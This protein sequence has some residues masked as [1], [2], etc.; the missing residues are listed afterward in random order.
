MHPKGYERRFLRTHDHFTPIS[1]QPMTEKAR[2][3]IFGE[4]LFDQFP[5]G[6]V[7]LGGAPFN[8][9]WHLQ[10]LGHAPLFIS[11]VGNDE[12]GSKIRHSMQQWGMDCSALQTD[13]HHPTGRVSVELKDGQP[14]FEILADQ[15]YDF[16]IS[17]QLPQIHEPHIIYHGSLALREHSSRATLDQLFETEN[18]QIFMDVNLRPPWWD[19][20]QVTS[21]LKAARWAKLNDVELNSLS[22]GSGD[23]ESQADALL[24]ACDLELLI[25]THGDQGAMAQKRDGEIARIRPQGNAEVMDTVGAGDAFS[26]VMIV[27]LIQGWELE[28]MLQR[29]QAF[30]SAIVGIRGA[31]PDSPTFYTPFVSQWSQA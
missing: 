18:H 23:L 29:A 5:D 31:T 19:K 25:V 28:L 15:A 9:A 3:L 13:T 14:A 10:A 11:R 21:R 4:V 20:A 17:E 24:Y 22:N 30:A 1:R 27:G 7:V 16:I 12:L 26:A 8:V 6:S 2:P